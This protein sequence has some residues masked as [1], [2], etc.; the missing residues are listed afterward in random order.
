VSI[1]EISV[2]VLSTGWFAE[3]RILPM[4]SVTAV[5]LHAAPEVIALGPPAVSVS[6]DW[7]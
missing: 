5:R 4:L 3:S 6:P 7:Q 1:D 2:N